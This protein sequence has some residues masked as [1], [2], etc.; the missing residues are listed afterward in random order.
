MFLS[1]HNR[2]LYEEGPISLRQDGGT[3][4]RAA[5]TSFERWRNRYDSVRALRRADFGRVGE[6]SFI[7]DGSTYDPNI[8]MPHP[9]FE[10]ADNIKK[11]VEKRSALR[12]YV[13]TGEIVRFNSLHFNGVAKSFMPQYCTAPVPG[14]RARQPVTR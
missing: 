10:M 6:A 1:V 3:V 7:I 14:A 12:F 4:R 13:P 11:I 8:N 5:K 9:G 2:Y